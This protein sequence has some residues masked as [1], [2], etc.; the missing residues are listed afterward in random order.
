MLNSP[1]CFVYKHF[2]G[3][4]WLWQNLEFHENRCQNGSKKTSQN[5]WLGDQGSDFWGFGRVFEGSDFWWIFDRQKICEILR[6]WQLRVGQMQKV[7]FC[8]EGRRIGRGPSEVRSLQKSEWRSDTP[9]TPLGE[10]GAADLI[11]SALPADAS[12][13]MN[14]LKIWKQMKICKV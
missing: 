9:L 14:I 10:T 4:R 12:Q 7:G 1:K 3:F 8:W 6:F 5:R 11:A 13:N 2:G